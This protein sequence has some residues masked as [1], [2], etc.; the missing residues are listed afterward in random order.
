MNGF[1]SQKLTGNL[2]NQNTKLVASREIKQHVLR[3]TVNVSLQLILFTLPRIV[4]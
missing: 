3:Q 2:A 1:L 4:K